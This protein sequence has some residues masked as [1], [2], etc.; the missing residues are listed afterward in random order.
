MGEQPVVPGADLGE[1][2]VGD[3]EGAGLR[4]G[5]VIEARRRHLGHAEL[6]GCKQATMTADHVAVGIDQDRDIETE[7]LDAAGDLPDLLR[8]VAPWVGRV[9][10]QLFNLPIS[11]RHPRSN[12]CADMR[13]GWACHL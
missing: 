1:P 3:H 6:A 13:G 12:G 11:D 10:F 5:E 2:I 7:C 9:R 8:A 4:R